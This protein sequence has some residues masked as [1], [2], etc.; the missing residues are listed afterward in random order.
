MAG[1]VPTVPL[2]R[3]PSRQ[4]VV[5][6]CPQLGIPSYRPLQPF[7]SRETDKQA[8]RQKSLGQAVTVE[9]A[10]FDGARDCLEGEQTAALRRTFSLVPQLGRSLTPES[11][12]DPRRRV[13]LQT[14]NRPPSRQQINDWFR[15]RAAMKVYDGGGGV[16]EAENPSAHNSS[17]C[18]SLEGSQESQK[19]KKSKSSPSRR[20]VFVIKH[21]EDSDGSEV[22]CS[23]L[24]SC[25]ESPQV[26]SSAAR[27]RPLEDNSPVFTR[28]TQVKTMTQP[29]RSIM[30]HR[31]SSGNSEKSV[32]N[33]SP[34]LLTATPRLREGLKVKQ[35]DER[36]ELPGRLKRRRISWH[37]PGQTVESC[38]QNQEDTSDKLSA[39]K[40]K[41]LSE[42][43]LNRI[44]EGERCNL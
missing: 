11:Q 44:Q 32:P 3:P 39:D 41:E 6:S 21:D 9:L 40:P 27:T 22:S 38:Q 4:D 1:A 43:L 26:L 33:L 8:D 28:V 23:S 31:S 15:M 36:E 42:S 17:Q 34:A 25:E 16:I 12:A 37:L 35:E 29:P 20:K 19:K 18:E 13:S 5:A 30:K 14:V 10:A 2:L 24:S 7:Y